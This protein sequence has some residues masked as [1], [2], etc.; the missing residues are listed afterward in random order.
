M[1]YLG[2]IFLTLISLAIGQER[3]MIFNA[4]PPNTQEGYLLTNNNGSGTVVSD[5]FYVSNDYVLEALT[6]YLKLVD[7]DSGSVTLSLQEDSD[8]TPGNTVFSWNIELDPTDLVLDDYL[9][10][11]VGE[12]H[13]MWGDNNYWLSVMVNEPGVQVLWGNSPTQF[14]YTASS[15]DLGL[16]W[17][18]PILGFAGAARIWAEQIYYPGDVEGPAELGDANLDGVVNILDIVQT[19][20]YILGAMEFTDAQVEQADYNEDDVVNILD[21]V[22]IVNYILSDDVQFMPQFLAEDLNPNSPYY[23][24]MIGPETFTGDISCY[25]FGKAG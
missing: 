2:L 25:Y 13:T 20:N 14:F 1:R 22:Q 11:T 5:R 24:Q 6:V 16:T 3:S 18:A 8:N 17:D 19:V 23:G 21:I 15:P 7:S 9:I 12:C 4:G 10:I